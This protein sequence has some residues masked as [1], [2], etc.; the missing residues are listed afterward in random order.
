MKTERIVMLVIVLL[1]LAG[2]VGMIS[3][4]NARMMPATHTV[5]QSIPDDRIPH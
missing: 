4:A 5:E 3:L 2:G 1:L